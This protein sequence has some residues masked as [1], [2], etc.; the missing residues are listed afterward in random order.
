MAIS[1][2]EL[3]KL[4][5]KHPELQK[6]RI[7]QIYRFDK[8]EVCFALNTEK[9]KKFVT[10]Q[11]PNTI[12]ISE[13][14]PLKDH[15][16]TGFGRF[17]RDNIAGKIC[18][19]F[20][21]IR[22][23]RTICID[24]NIYQIYIEMYGKGN[25]IV[26]QNGNIVMP[27]EKQEPRIVKE[28]PYEP[29]SSFDTF[30]ATVEDIEKHKQSFSDTHNISKFCASCLGFGKGYA[31]A[32]CEIINVD[33][34]AELELIPTEKIH[35]GI[36]ELLTKDITIKATFVEKKNTAY[37]KEVQ[38]I[39]GIIAAQEKQL[40]K[41]KADSAKY[42]S[43]GEYIYNNYTTFQKLVDLYNE[44]KLT[45]AVKGLHNI[46]YKKPYVEITVAD[47]KE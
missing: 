15:K 25:M 4:F 2:L 40:E 43:I 37:E 12:L 31:E 18:S 30:H 5:E 1:A 16:E 29:D 47:T 11:I 3:Y 20:A 22:S 41:V 32:L 35:K 44:E 6:S 34:E 46:T 10:F 36:Q 27:L 45:E 13:G 21:Q 7:S 19:S 26:V 23:E 24:V 8:K 33:P 42:N 9:G 17:L 28:K 38:R 14:K 39:K